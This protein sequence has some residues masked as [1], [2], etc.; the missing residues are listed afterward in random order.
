MVE[1][2]VR[3]CDN[4]DNGAGQAMEFLEAMMELDE[5]K[6]HSDWMNGEGDRQRKKDF[7]WRYQLRM[8]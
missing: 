3:H 6:E 4:N 1:S 8:F 5:G 2:F 7:K